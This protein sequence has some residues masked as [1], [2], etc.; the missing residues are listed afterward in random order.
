MA[1]LC[2]IGINNTPHELVVSHG[3]LKMQRLVH[4]TCAFF[5]SSV[6]QLVSTKNSLDLQT[7]KPNRQSN[8]GTAH[9]CVSLCTVIAHETAQNSSINLMCCQSSLP[10]LMCWLSAGRRENSVGNFPWF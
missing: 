9:L 4:M 5:H 1:Y 3:K 2:G 6:K 10:V 7:Y 8:F